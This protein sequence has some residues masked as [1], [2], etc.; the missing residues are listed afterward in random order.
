MK[1]YILFAILY[2]LFTG[3]HK[4]FKKKSDQK[5]NEIAILTI[6]T[7]ICF[8]LS[9]IWIP[10][11]VSIDSKYIWLFVLK[12]FIIALSWFCTLKVMKTADVSLVALTTVL[13]AVITFLI[14][15]FA[16]HESATWLQIVGAVVIVGGAVLINLMNKT[17]SKKANVTQILLLLLIAINSSASTV[18]DKVTTSVLEF[19]QVQFWF[20]LFVFLFSFLFFSIECLR[21]KKFLIEKNDFKNFWIY[22]VAFTL[23]IGD[24]FLFLSYKC[25]D[26]QMIIISI[27]SQLKTVVAV[28]LGIVLFKEK[29]Y[30]KKIL[31]SLLIFGGI[32][33]VSL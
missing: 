19:H 12:G 26:S 6:F 23:F 18:I 4:V 33:M 30:M 20:L 22:L 32:L 10:F 29:N 17:D 27:V 5:S 7:F 24:I 9:L 14:G 11:N 15:V 25:A 16:F 8:M 3:A 28:L 2:A 21:N 13:S 1:V 31:I